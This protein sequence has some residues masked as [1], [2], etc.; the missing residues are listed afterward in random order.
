[1]SYL[2]GHFSG[3]EISKISEISKLINAAIWQETKNFNK[4]SVPW[5][6]GNWSFPE[7]SVFQEFSGSKFE[8]P[9]ERQK[10]SGIFRNR[11]EISWFFRKFRVFAKKTNFLTKNRS[12][13]FVPCERNAVSSIGRCFAPDSI[14]YLHTNVYSIYI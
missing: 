10:F 4:F 8:V 13:N 5:H 14:A 3:P 11:I 2:F 6:I 1:M 9:Q 7:I 12:E